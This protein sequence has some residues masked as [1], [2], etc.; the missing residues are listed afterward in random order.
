MGA[1]GCGWDVEYYDR[2]GKGG[3]ICDEVS[4]RMIDVCYLQEVR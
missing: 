4:K 2:S 3:D 1:L